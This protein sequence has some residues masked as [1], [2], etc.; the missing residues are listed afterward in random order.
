M[1][2]AL[3]HKTEI[4]Y[5]SRVSQRAVDRNI[6]RLQTLI[7]MRWS[8]PKPPTQGDT[9]TET[10]FAWLPTKVR[11]QM[12]WLERYYVHKRYNS[13]WSG[14]GSGRWVTYRSLSKEP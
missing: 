12:I 7:L 8:L 1:A 10:H 5:T 13:L 9:R 6:P 11:N 2:R 14:P 4:L 3:L